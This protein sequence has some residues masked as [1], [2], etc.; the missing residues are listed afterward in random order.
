MLDKILF[1]TLFINVRINMQY[2]LNFV[3]NMHKD[4]IIICSCMQNKKS[5]LAS[6][7]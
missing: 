3:K 5:P 7:Y 6:N 4:V 2:N 1:H